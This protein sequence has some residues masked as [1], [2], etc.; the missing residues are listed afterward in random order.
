MRLVKHL[1]EIT[2]LSD[3]EL[4]EI[5]DDGFAEYK[6]I[7]KGTHKLWPFMLLALNQAFMKYQI[8]FLPKWSRMF[9]RA[10]K[11]AAAVTIPTGAILIYV[12]KSDK[13]AL[14][15]GNVKGVKK[16]LRT[17]LAHELVHR[18]Q[19][20]KVPAI[21]TS[22]RTTIDSPGYW[23]HPME[24]EAY[25]REV[26]IELKEFGI[27]DSITL[28]YMMRND[29]KKGWKSFLKRAYQ[30]IDMS[31]DKNLKEKFTVQMKNLYKN[32][33]LDWDDITQALEE[34]DDLTKTLK[35]K[36]NK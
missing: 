17:D 15:S 26:P 2:K 16:M 3:E 7:M 18:K 35:V 11:G 21:A 24:I 6:K 25:A 9:M 28:Y 23:F 4:D 29:N 32:K 1:N 5:I 36:E 30:Y 34:L 20:K 13:K 10:S 27:S 31:G 19:F 22:A 14:K 33:E 8:H 12:S